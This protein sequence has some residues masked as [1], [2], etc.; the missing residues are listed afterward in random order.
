MK[1]DDEDLLGLLVN[2]KLNRRGQYICDCPFCGKPKH[3]Y[4]SKATQMWDCKKCG[5]YGNVYK[6]LKHL[7]K[8]Y[9]LKG[10]T[11]EIKE[12]IQKLRDKILAEEE[13]ELEIPK[14]KKVPLP[15]G[16]KI[17]EKNK[18]LQKER[19]LTREEIRFYEI[20]GTKIVSK[21]DN[22]IIFPVRDGGVVC[23]FVGRYASKNV[24]ENRPRYNN[25][26]GTNFRLLLG[27]YDEIKE[28]ETNTVIL[29]EGMFDKIAVDTRLG[30]RDADEVK[31]VCTFG[32][33]ISEEQIFKLKKKNVS[34]IILLYDFDAIN[35]MKKTGVELS[36]S[37][38]TYITFTTAKDIDECSIEKTAEVFENLHDPV[39]FC[40]DVVGK[41]KS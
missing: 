6:L 12:T 8:L 30:L 15:V 21:Y 29:V 41:I 22:Y 10:K 28:N 40:Y 26:E 36:K 13:D 5:E 20:G 14:L 32:K 27:G 39:S 7:D 34:T 17:F 24:P 23:G 16:F 4:I 1:I 31:C 35:D 18:Y 9:L 37:F 19:G 38:R 2:P 11:V 25:S 33:K 3:F